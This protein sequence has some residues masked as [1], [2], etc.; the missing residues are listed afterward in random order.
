MPGHLLGQTITR[1][2]GPSEGPA[3]TLHQWE[4]I[5]ALSIVAN[6]NA[7]DFPNRKKK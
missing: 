7:D 4:P 6:G 1:A 3:S 5:D 2:I